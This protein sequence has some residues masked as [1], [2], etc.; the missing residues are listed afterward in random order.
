MDP[1]SEKKEKKRKSPICLMA[2]MATGGRAD[3]T[4]MGTSAFTMEDK[5]FKKL[6]R[7]FDQDL[8]VLKPFFSKLNS[9]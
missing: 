3:S 4:A 2:L 6:G 9:S 5:N 7:W 8:Q 1:G